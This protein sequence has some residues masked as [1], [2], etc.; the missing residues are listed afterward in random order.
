M[1]YNPVI[2]SVARQSIF[3]FS[4]VKRGWIAASLALLAMTF[5]STPAAALTIDQPLPNPAQETRARAL[6]QELRCVVCQGESVADSPADV[7]AD[8]R[9]AVRQAVARGE[10]DE[11]IKQT[12]VAHYGERVLMLPSFREGNLPLWLAPLVCL[13]VGGVF[14]WRRLFGRQS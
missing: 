8:M 1:K 3:A 4:G 12:F 7:A 13:L 6:F 11:T 5:F 9:R 2:A 10:T 14:A